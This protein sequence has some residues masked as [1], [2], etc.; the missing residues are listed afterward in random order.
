MDWGETLRVTL[1]LAADP[2]S[3]V[4]AAIAGW[5]R[6]ATYTDL[7]LMDLF[8]LQYASKSKKT[9]KPYPRPWDKKKEPRPGVSIAEFEEMKRRQFGA[10]EH[11]DDDSEGGEDG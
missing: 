7:V 11:E 1:V 3:A 5:Q 2:S 4:S 10:A 9:T 8:D 6:P